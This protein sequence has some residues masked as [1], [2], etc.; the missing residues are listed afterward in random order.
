MF[1]S[2]NLTYIFLERVFF[3]PFLEHDPKPFP[4]GCACPTEGYFLMGPR[5]GSVGQWSGQ[6]REGQGVPSSP[7]NH[8]RPISQTSSCPSSL[9]PQPP[10][11]AAVAVSP[12]AGMRKAWEG[13]G[14]AGKQEPRRRLAPCFVSSGQDRRR[15]WRHPPICTTSYFYVF[16]NLKFDTNSVWLPYSFWR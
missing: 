15:N 3:C 2:R 6:G 8:P 13:K 4:F 5:P 1:I 11:T 10:A 12:R 14:L 16:C 9:L 7:K